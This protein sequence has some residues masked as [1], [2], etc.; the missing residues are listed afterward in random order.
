MLLP[1]V[2]MEWPLDE[3]YMADVVAISGRWNS[4]FCQ[5][6]PIWQMLLPKWHRWNSHLGWLVCWQME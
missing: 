3:D 6:Q 5:M 4:L 1:F 2:A